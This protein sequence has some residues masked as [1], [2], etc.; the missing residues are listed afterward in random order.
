MKED[1]KYKL[2]EGDGITAA[3]VHRQKVLLVKRVNIPIISNPGIWTFIMGK[4]NKNET[5]IETAYREI[6][7]EVRLGRVD[8]EP[9]V[10]MDE[11]L[12]FDAVRQNKMWKNSFFVFKTENPKVRINYENTHFRW[13]EISELEEERE[14]T[15]IFVNKKS[16]L[17]RIKE[18]AEP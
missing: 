14:Y 10:Q 3:I 16:A 17:D 18:A 7:E 2:V 5:H 13:A 4:R 12:M 1:G 9:L 8:L 6:Q 11:V 15:N